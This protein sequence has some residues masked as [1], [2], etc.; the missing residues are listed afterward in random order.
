MRFARVAFHRL[1][2]VFSR[3]R[4]EADM[5]RELELHLEQLTREH[6]AA[7]PSDADARQAARRQFG[8]LGIVKEQCRD[9][10]R[11][12]WL[13]DLA[14][15]L[16]YTARLVRRSPGFALTAVLSL[17]LG[18]GAN[19]AIFSLV[20]AF[21]LR[22]LPFHEPHRLV[23]LFERNVI[24]DEQRMAVAPGN[25]LDWQQFSTSLEHISAFTTSMVPLTAGGGSDERVGLCACSANLFATLGVSP[26]VGRAFRADE[27][28]GGAPRVAVISHNLWQGQFGGAASVVGQT[29]RLDGEAYEVVGVAPRGFMFPDRT[30]DVWLPLL[31]RLPLQ[32]QRRHDLHFLQVIGRVK[33]GVTLEQAHAEIDGITSRYK[34]AHPHEATG[35]GAIAVPLHAHLVSGV[36]R[37]LMVLLGAVVCVLLIACVNIANLMLTR[38]VARTR[39]IGIRNALGATR[40]RIIR[41]LLT[42]SVVLGLVGGA[43][44]AMLAAWIAGVLVTR[45]P[46]A[47]AILPAGPPPL[48]P[49]VLLFALAIAL[50]TG[51][52]VGLVPAIR[53]SRSDVTTDLKDKT[54]SATA[55]RAQGPFRDVLVTAEVALSLVLLIAAGLLLHSFLRLYQVQPGIRVD[56]TLTMGTSLPR[57]SYPEPAQRSAIL[58][59]LGDHLRAIPG[60]KSAGLVSCAPL[61]GTCNVLFFYIE[62][63]P[64]TPGKFFAAMERSADPEYFSAA[65]IPLLRGRTFTR[66]DGVGFD[67]K[68]PRLGSI[69]ISESMAKTFFPG[70][71]AIGKRVFFDFELQREKIDGLPAPR[72]EVVG[73]V[74]DVLPRLDASVT[75]TL[76]RPLLDLASRNV[77]ILLH[78]ALEPQSVTPSVRDEI[79]KLDRLMPVYQVRTLEDLLGRSTADRRFSLSL[80]AAFAALALL[81]AAVG[82]YGVVSYAV[83][84]RTAE[85]GIRLALGAS[86]ANVRRMMVMQGLKPTIVGVALGLIAAAFA[87]RVLRNLLFEVTPG[88]P[89]TFSLVPPLLLAVAALACYL[90]AARATRLDPTVAL[91]AE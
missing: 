34:R 52:A 35:Q 21:L 47:G 36:R 54:R 71:D 56:H 31:A 8:A 74:G 69:V 61:T 55:N 46:G 20:S 16:L 89:L 83:S 57:A 7:G 9:V 88:D 87:S 90:P 33:P 44:G 50:T 5:D 82:L 11:V 24:G 67:P 66:Q 58:G 81:L 22:A 18:I 14:K 68:T 65:G 38:A 85:I 43:V 70:E 3:S 78:T 26:I 6:I 40:G 2:S 72:Y 79:R 62:G 91:R 13:D 45:A 49:A 53:A 1:R 32:Q 30:V 17:A 73:V 84:Q 75:P 27:D 77:S 25:F 63:R 19:T 29:L 60:V 12:R 64:F 37:P 10:H 80:F 41:Q 59:E 86:Q 51:L 28:R 23:A 39:E 76:Y 4:V 42:E 48:D 15:D